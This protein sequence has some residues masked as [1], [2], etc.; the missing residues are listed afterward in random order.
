MTPIAHKL[1]L[2][3][4]HFHRATQHVHQDLF[5]G[6]HPYPRVAAEKLESLEPA[7]VKEPADAELLIFGFLCLNV[8]IE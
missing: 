3:E 2:C 5:F 4:H 8:M 6:F 7:E 1:V